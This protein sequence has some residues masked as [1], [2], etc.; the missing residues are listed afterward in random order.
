MS[1]LTTAVLPKIYL[2]RHGQTEW[3]VL[4]RHTGRTDI[5]LTNRGE[6]EAKSLGRRLNP[7]QFAH[8]ISSPL[9]RARRTCELAG[10]EK[11]E[12]EPDLMEWAYGELE[13]ITSKEFLQSNPDFDL[14]RDGPPAGE[15]L[16]EVGARADRMIQRLRSMEG[17]ILLFSHGHFLRILAARWIGLSA[18]QAA[19]LHLLTA[20]LSILSYEHTLSRPAIWLWNDTSHLSSEG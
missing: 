20:S 8:I 19:N 18:G 12:A 7:I 9:Q 11:F 14:F 6:E 3:S 13:G 17:D 10:F 16:I 5:P 15:T 2:A 1:T 4:G